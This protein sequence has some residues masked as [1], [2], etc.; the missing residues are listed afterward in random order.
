M[1][2]N[3]CYIATDREHGMTQEAKKTRIIS[4]RNRSDDN[5][6][7]NGDKLTSSCVPQ[8]GGKNLYQ[9]LYTLSEFINTFDLPQTARVVEGHYGV[10]EASTI[11]NDIVLLLCCRRATKMVLTDYTVSFRE[12]CFSY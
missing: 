8:I 11:P 12:T 3:L 9:K 5:F 1:L 4:V 6:A 10:T 7:T 2:Y